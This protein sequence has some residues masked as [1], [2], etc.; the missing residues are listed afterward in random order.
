M[1]LNIKNISVDDAGNYSCVAKNRFGEVKKMYYLSV[2]G[3]EG[4]TLTYVERIIFIK[5][6]ILL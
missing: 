6:F 2:Q 4:N 1:I 5:Y 3:K